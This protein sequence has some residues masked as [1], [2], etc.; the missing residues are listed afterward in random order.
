MMSLQQ[1]RGYKIWLGYS[2]YRTL[3]H[4]VG[5]VAMINKS[6]YW[7]WANLTS[8]LLAEK[9]CPNVAIKR[10]ILHCSQSG[11]SIFIFLGS[12][13]SMTIYSLPGTVLQYR[14]QVSVVM[15]PTQIFC[16]ANK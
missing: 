9:C 16:S 12:A 14:L 4:V 7:R 10:I 5:L 6:Q 15:K 13:H 8:A 3:F 2:R 1:G 11:D